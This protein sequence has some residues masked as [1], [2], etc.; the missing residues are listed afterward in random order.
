[1][2]II[3]GGMCVNPGCVRSS[4]KVLKSEEDIELVK[5]GDMIVLP[6]SH[7]MFSLAL[8]KASAVVCERG[9]RLSHICIVALEMGIPCLTAVPDATNILVSGQDIMVNT[10]EMEIC[11]Y[12]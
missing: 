10:G 5:E 7:P 2:K 12:E 3:K 11:V 8:F 6:Y 4:C 9:G 1:M